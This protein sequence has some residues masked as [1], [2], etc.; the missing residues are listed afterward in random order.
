MTSPGPKRPSTL[1]SVKRLA[2]LST[3]MVVVGM[4]A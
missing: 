2:V 3:T 1:A 4:R